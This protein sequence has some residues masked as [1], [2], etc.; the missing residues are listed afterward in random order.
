M[1]ETL[2]SEDRVNYVQDYLEDRL[3]IL[4]GGR[5]AEKLVLGQVSTG[6]SDDLKQCTRLARR[7][8]TQWGMSKNL[9]PINFPQHEDHPFLG[10]EMTQPKDFSD[11]TAH[12]I[13]EEIRELVTRSDTETYQLLSNNRAQLDLLANALLDHETLE[14]EEIEH[15]LGTNSIK[16]HEEN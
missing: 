2:P 1:T 7:M 15:L 5:C 12:L 11:Q 8:V 3:H 4:L 10:M 14:Q 9:G 16:N 6:A 13:D